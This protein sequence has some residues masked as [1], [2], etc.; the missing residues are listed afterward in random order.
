MPKFIPKPEVNEVICVR[1][2]SEKLK[3]IDAI[4]YQNNMS[5]NKFIIQCIDFAME[6]L[7][8]PNT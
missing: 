2:N 3:K 7:D 8:M 5:R 1:I 6:N 4:A